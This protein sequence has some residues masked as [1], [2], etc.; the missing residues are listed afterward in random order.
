MAGISVLRLPPWWLA[1]AVLL[2]LVFLELVEAGAGVGAH[3]AVERTG[4]IV[5]QHVASHVLDQ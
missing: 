3:R 4:V 1:N 5:Q 2:Q